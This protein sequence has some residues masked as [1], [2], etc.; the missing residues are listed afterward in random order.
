MGQFSVTFSV[1]L[2][3]FFWCLPPAWADTPG[4]FSN[5][6]AELAKKPGE[7]LDKQLEQAKTNYSIGNENIAAAKRLIAEL[8]PEMED[9]AKAIRKQAK[10]VA[11][12]ETRGL[13]DFVSKEPAAKKKSNAELLSLQGDLSEAQ[14]KVDQLTAEIKTASAAADKARSESDRVIRAKAALSGEVEKEIK[15]LSKKIL[16]QGLQA[17]LNDV[18]TSIQSKQ[19]DLSKLDTKLQVLE[20]AYDNKAVGGYLKS[21]MERLVNSPV[22]C[23]A[24]KNCSRDDKSRITLDSVFHDERG[25]LRNHKTEGDEGSANDTH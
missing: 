4:T 23:E 22:F 3:S 17:N 13:L 16:E 15:W 24:Q 7:N 11:D 25:N 1:L 8:K 10:V 9:L 19:L 6:L 21:K 18:L 2:G 14:E 5:L 12:S 20:M